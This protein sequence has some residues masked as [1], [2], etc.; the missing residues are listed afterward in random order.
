M[1]E[2]K[3]DPLDVPMEKVI[4]RT[5]DSANKG[6]ASKTNAGQPDFA[7]TP[8][9]EGSHTQETVD[10]AEQLPDEPEKQNDLA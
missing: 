1:P 8:R 9:I 5:D 4:T 3:R 7:D 10:P 6:S 2:N